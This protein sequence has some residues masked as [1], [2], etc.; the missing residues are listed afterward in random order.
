M[1]DTTRYTK[2]LNWV[3]W[4]GP[5]VCVCFTYSHTLNSASVCA[6]LTFAHFRVWPLIYLLI[7]VQLFLFMYRNHRCA[8]S[9]GMWSCPCSTY[10]NL[11]LITNISACVSR[12][13]CS[14]RG[15]SFSRR[16]VLNVS[17]VTHTEYICP[18]GPLFAIYLSRPYRQNGVE[19]T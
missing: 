19:V 18:S 7:S 9:W 1:A 13:N 8:F 17:N 14:W 11:S 16:G 5:C 4:K 10:G 12:T 15:Y 3:S 6:F 2:C